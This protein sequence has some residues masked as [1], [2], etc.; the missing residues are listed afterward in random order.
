MNGKM[1]FYG[2]IT[3]VADA[4]EVSVGKG[5][6]VK[7]RGAWNEK[8][9]GE[10]IASFANFES[11]SEYNNENI[12]KFFK[13]GKNVSVRGSISEDSYEDKNGNKV[14]TYRYRVDGF[15]LLDNRNEKPQE[16]TDEG[17]G[18]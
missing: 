3:L 13:K 11:W 1:L 7:F 15:D 16:K 5:T 8:R 12:M 17:P 18:F 10:N 4:E 6:L 9:K 14:K 2:N